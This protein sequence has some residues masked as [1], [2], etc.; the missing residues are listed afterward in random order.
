MRHVVR[1]VVMHIASVIA[2]TTAMNYHA[3][4]SC[5]TEYYTMIGRHIGRWTRRGVVTTN[6]TRPAHVQNS[7]GQHRHTRIRRQRPNIPIDALA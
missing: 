2:L 4:S 6:K 5:V 1:S 3:T 7:Y